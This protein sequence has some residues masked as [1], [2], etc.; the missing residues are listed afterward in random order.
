MT[1]RQLRTVRG[2]AAATIATL[3]AAVSHT[4]GGGAPPSALLMLSVSVLLTPLAVLLAGRATRFASI[5]ATVGVTQI[6]FHA[7]FEVTGPQH[8]PPALVGLHQ[9]GALDPAVLAPLHP[10]IGHAA[11]S[12]ALMLVAHSCAAIVTALLLW[13]GEMLLRSIGQWV[14]AVLRRAQT[15]PLVNAPLRA[16]LVDAAALPALSRIRFSDL[17][18]RGP[19]ALSCC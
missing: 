7:L 1:P 15:L 13:R 2:A 19:P 12:D 3:F 14:H 18:R 4:V 6:A 5:A 11:H 17:C 8:A 9:H 16:A 10:S